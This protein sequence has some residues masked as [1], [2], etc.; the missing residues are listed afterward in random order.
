MFPPCVP[1]VTLVTACFDMSNY[2]SSQRDIY[3][4][5]EGIT[6]FHCYIVFFG[7]KK[8]IP[9]VKQ[10]RERYD[11]LSLSYFIEMDIKDI[12]SLQYL[13][14]VKKNRD[15]FWA[16][17]DKRTCSETHL[18]TCNK[19]DFVLQIIKDNPFRTSKF[20]W[21]DAFLGD[22][23]RICEDFTMNKLV[24]VLNNITDKF[25]IQVLNV[26]DKK[27]KLPEHKHEFYSRYRWVVCGGFFTCSK[28]TG[29][30]ILNR[31]KEIFIETTEMGYGHGEEMFYLE[32]LDEFYDDIS[33]SYGDY[34]QIINN[35]IKPT[36]N[37][38]YIL[39]NILRK[40][41]NFGYHK[42]AFDCA[43][44]CVK[45]IE[46][47]KVHVSPDVRF[48]FLYNYYVSA[49]YFFPEEAKKICKY[50]LEIS[51]QNPDLKRIYNNN[52]QFYDQQF[53]FVMK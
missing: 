16:S 4:E 7:D 2:V 21:C 38:D 20:G 23:C 5:I 36:C 1:D 24:Y 40:Y 10:L 14:K 48:S 31:L 12:W 46:S 45:Q 33:R 27:Y 47:Y 28:T 9:F 42:E 18:I 37:F 51:S 13:D 15:N 26:T 11:L 17:E 25:H 6:K 3:K 19:F 22:N 29:V 41:I 34:G 43:K 30:K 49:Y 32:V 53:S 50:I 52:K 8:T 44:K 35:F 39:N